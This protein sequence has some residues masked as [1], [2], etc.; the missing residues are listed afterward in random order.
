MKPPDTIDESMLAP[1]GRNCLLCYRHLGKNP[2][3][4]C[5]VRPAEPGAYQ[6]KCY[7]RACTESRGY[8]TCAD[9]AE[10][11]CKRVKTFQKRYM[12]G[13]GVDLSALAESLQSSGAEALLREQL[14]ANTCADCGHLIDLHFGVCSGCARQYPIGKGRN[15]V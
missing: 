2:C 12:D 7:M 13:Y 15:R 11:P 9:C 1:G 10:R 3:P 14:Q 4:G 8:T 5:R 6:S